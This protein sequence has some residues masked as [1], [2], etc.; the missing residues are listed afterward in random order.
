MSFLT[1]HYAWDIS[2]KECFKSRNVR[3][4]NIGVSENRSVTVGLEHTS[5]QTYEYHE[6]NLGI[7]R[8]ND[9]SQRVYKAL[10]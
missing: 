2:I 8:Q 9:D 1:Q 3:C 4:R 6:D 5:V 7:S 10:G